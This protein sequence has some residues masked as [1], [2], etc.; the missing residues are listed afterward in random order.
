MLKKEEDSKTWP[1]VTEREDKKKYVV[2]YTH[3]RLTALFRG[4]PGWA[5]TRKV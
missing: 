1:Y 2:D 4:L 3:T 5:S